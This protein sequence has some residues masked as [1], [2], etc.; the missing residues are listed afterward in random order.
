MKK[1]GTYK[2]K[3]IEKK[4]KPYINVDKKNDKNLMRVKLQNINF[5]NK[6]ALLQ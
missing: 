2:L 5:I 6:R 3:K 4:L 1:V